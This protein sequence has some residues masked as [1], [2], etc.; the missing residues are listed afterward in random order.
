MAKKKQKKQ[1]AAGGTDKSGKAKPKKKT[2]RG[3]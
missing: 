3:Q 2:S 1:A